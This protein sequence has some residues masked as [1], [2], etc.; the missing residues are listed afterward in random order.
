VTMSPPRQHVTQISPESTELLIKEARRQ[1]VLRRLRVLSMAIVVLLAVLVGGVI[2]GRGTNSPAK[3]GPGSRSTQFV[4]VPCAIAQLRLADRG[5]D[6]ATGHWTQLFQF[7]NVSGHACSLAGYPK[8]TLKTATGL[9][10]SLAVTDVKSDALEY[11]GDSRRGALP[12]AELSARGGR[13]SFW[14]AGSDMPLGYQP[15]SACDFASEVLVTPP[16]TR[17]ALDHRVGRIPFT[18]CENSLQVTP[19]LSGQSGSIPAEPLC[20]YALAGPSAMSCT[21]RVRF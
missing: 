1:M 12:P 11:I 9:D 3:T 15:P 16:G 4:A 19:V 13:A 10:S 8:I 17:S 5:S 6:V 21:G 7:T 20:M 14:I 18:W 2:L